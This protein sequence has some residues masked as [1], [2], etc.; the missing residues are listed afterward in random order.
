LLNELGLI[1]GDAPVHG[2]GNVANAPRPSANA[3]SAGKG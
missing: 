1:P 3:A 2:S